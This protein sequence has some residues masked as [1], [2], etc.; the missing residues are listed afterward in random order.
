MRG[1]DACHTCRMWET[2][3]PDMIVAL[4]G[5]F[6]TV[7]IAYCT[8]R[9]NR[10]NTETHAL[11]SLIGELSVKRAIAP[12]VQPVIVDGAASTDAFKHANL[13]VIGMRDE[14]RRTRNLVRPDSILQRNLSQMTRAC[15]IYL[16]TIEAEPEAYLLLLEVLRTELSQEVEG[17]ASSRGGVTSARPG[18]RAFESPGA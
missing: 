17:I 3:W 10:R 2:F 4:A 16:E 8:F 1:E 14:I 5:A 6:F 18:E 7:I 11:N 12:Q 13:S 15:N 9:I